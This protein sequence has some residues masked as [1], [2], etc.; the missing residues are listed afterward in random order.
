MLAL[1]NRCGD[2]SPAVWRATKHHSMCTGTYT[3][4]IPDLLDSAPDCVV[5]SMYTLISSGCIIMCK[6]NNILVQYR[7][8]RVHII[9]MCPCAHLPNVKCYLQ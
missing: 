1:L 3:L 5:D 6:I 9:I 2:G 8:M 4:Q 7:T